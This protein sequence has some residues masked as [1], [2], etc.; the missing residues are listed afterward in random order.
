MEERV[1]HGDFDLWSGIY[2]VKTAGN[3]LFTFT[4]LVGLNARSSTHKFN[5]LV[6]KGGRFWSRPTISSPFS[7]N[8]SWS[9]GISLVDM[10]DVLLLDEG[11]EVRILAN[12]GNLSQ[13]A[14]FTGFLMLNS[15]SNDSTSEWL[16]LLSFLLFSKSYIMTSSLMH[17]WMKHCIH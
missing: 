14:S 12:M 16:C 15:S 7:Y 5:L 13:P 2:T 8:Y 9:S 11:D 17:S 3:Y 4:G 10:T 1:E 6:F